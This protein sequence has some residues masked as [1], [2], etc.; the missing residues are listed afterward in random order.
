MDL[1]THQ[2]IQQVSDHNATAGKIEHTKTRAVRLR[3]MDAWICLVW[4]V[5]DPEEVA[6]LDH[7]VVHRPVRL[8]KIID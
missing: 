3:P 4:V 5:D 2:S 1:L 7:D 8:T 6:V